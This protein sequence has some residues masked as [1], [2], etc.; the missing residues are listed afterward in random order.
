MRSLQ[1][2]RAGIVH[3]LSATEYI[4][5]P[6]G[7]LVVSNGLVQAC[8]PASDLLPSLPPSTPI[9]TFPDSLLLPGFIDTHIHY[10]QVEII[11]SYGAQ[12]LDWLQNY[13]FPAEGKFNDL[14]E[15]RK[16]ADFFLQELL[17]NGTTTA[18]VFCAVYKNSVTAFFEAAQAMGLRMIAGKVMMDRNAPEYLLDTPE[19]SYT[20]SKELIERWHG[21]DRLLYAVT[22]RFAITSTEPQLHQASRLLKEFPGVYLHTHLAENRQEVAFVQELFPQST[23]YL[24]VYNRCELTGPKSVFAHSIYL[25]PEDRQCLSETHSSIS[26]CPTSNLFIGSGLFDFKSTA[27]SGIAIGLGTDIGGGTSFSML[28]TL[29]EAYKVMQLQGQNLDVKKSIYL[30]TL[31]GA[32]ALS[33]D[34][35]LGNF[36]V[37]KEADFCVL[38]LKATPLLSFRMQTA[39]NIEEKLFALITLAD[40]RVIRATYALGRCVHRRDS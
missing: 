33:L 21:V 23:S 5:Y 34:H 35:I 15:N 19:S 12:L 1:A 36:E 14:R 26:F 38:D 24:D 22:P 27:E 10:P 40:D 32:K 6:D 11:G 37:G 28:R 16:V 29:A 4:H 17:R 18:L 31:G 3:S 8:G 30:A 9:A 2:F 20:D 7:L 25:S 13:T 39:R